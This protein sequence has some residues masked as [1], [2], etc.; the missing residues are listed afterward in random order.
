MILGRILCHIR[1][2]L[3]LLSLSLSQPP[4]LSLN[5]SLY[6][7]LSPN[8]GTASRAAAFVLPESLSKMW[9]VPR[10]S[11]AEIYLMHPRRV[12]LKSILG[13]E[14]CQAL[15]LV[16]YAC[17]SLRERVRRP[18][19]CWDHMDHTV[20]EYENI[21]GLVAHCFPK[22]ALK[23]RVSSILPCLLFVWPV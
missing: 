22:E 13:Y 2:F 16:I 20:I 5:I 21:E 15:S 18:S 12:L 4:P 8:E 10:I 14:A 11:R 17:Y 9:T 3:L 6:V 23:G 7:C 19:L 1:E